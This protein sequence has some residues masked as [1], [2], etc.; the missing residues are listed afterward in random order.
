[1]R[2]IRRIVGRIL[3]ERIK[4][5]RFESPAQE[6]LLNLLVAAGHVRQIVD[7]VC[8]RQGITRAQYNALRI[9]RGAHPAGYPRGEISARLLERAPDVTRLIDRLERL[10]LAERV[11]S[12]T[13]RRLSMTHITRQGLA[14]LK[15]VD[16]G[17][18]AVQRRFAAGLS[19][20]DLRKFSRFCE[21]IYGRG[22]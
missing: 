15:K 5:A 11:R 13:D 21:Q 3:S 14:L 10:G 20:G 17:V 22:E 18:R 6:A 19:P 7:E 4:Q 8:A 1:M 2:V 9:L 16:P 12:G